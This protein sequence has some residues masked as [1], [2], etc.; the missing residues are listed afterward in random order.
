MICL[1]LHIRE[2]SSNRSFIMA[3]KW[4]AL[5]WWRGSF[6]LSLMVALV[7]VVMALFQ[8]KGRGNL[9]KGESGG[10]YVRKRKS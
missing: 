7:A 4:L 5:V 3:R 8:A 2:T 6:T 1:H 10:V 9:V